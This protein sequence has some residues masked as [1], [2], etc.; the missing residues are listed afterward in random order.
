MVWA[1]VAGSVFAV[2]FSDVPDTHVNARAI[3]DLKDANIISGYADSQFRPDQPL[4][5]AEAVAIILKAAGITASRT[6]VRIPFADV[7]ESAWFFPMIQKG[8]EMGKLR[9]Y[10]DGTFKPGNNINLPESIALSLA[11]FGID[12]SRINVEPVIYRGLSV[13]EWYS[14]PLQYAKNNNLIEPGAN[15]AVDPSAPVTRGQFAEIIYRLRIAR[16]TGAP[17]NLA[18]FWTFAEHQDNFWRL[19]TPPGW[20]IF[21]GLRNSVIW[22]RDFSAGTANPFFTRVW[23][24]GARVSIS[25]VDNGENLTAAQFFANLKDLYERTFSRVSTHSAQMTL[26]GKSAFKLW[27][28]D[29]R[30][31]DAAVQL[32]GGNFLIF[33]GE[34]G[35]APIG[36]FLKKQVEAVIMS[37]EFI[38]RPSTPP[39]P[40]IPLAERL[41]TLRENILIAGKWNEISPLFPDKRL[42]STDAIGVGTGPVDYYFSREANLTVKLERNSGTILNTREGETNAF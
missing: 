32:P 17:Y 37:Y 27:V 7:P 11:F 1:F 20:E 9:G 18:S 19:K 15:G 24:S 14:K 5:R 22:K 12:A 6:S 26:A 40:T 21:K 10:S 33:N 42:T 8:V 38:E 13:T 28:P 35:D 34:Y 3:Q 39:Q 31:F 16:Q 25:M 30:I 29:R 4:A 36:E 23:P 41:E 2:N